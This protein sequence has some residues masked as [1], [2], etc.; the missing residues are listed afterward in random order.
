MKKNLKIATVAAASIF[1]S[2]TNL[3]A[4]DAGEMT[5]YK[6]PWCGC[7]SVWADAMKQAGYKVKLV[8]LEDLTV[9][10]RQAGVPEQLN[11]CH[12]VSYGKYVL[13]GH[14]PLEAIRKLDKEKPDIRGIGVAGMPSGSLGM[15][16]DPKA[17]YDVMAFTHAPSK[18]PTLYYE[19]G[20]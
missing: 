9:I 15:G 7:C 8:D 19:A 5:V 14:V 18:L 10:K 11:S 17:R 16:Y 13:E 12:T 20:K 3:G 2:I 6:N 1:T 4:Q